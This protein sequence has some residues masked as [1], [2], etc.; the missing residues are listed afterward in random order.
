MQ[1][2]LSMIAARPRRVAPSGGQAPVFTGAPSIIGTPTVGV[3]CTCTAGTYTGTPT[4]TVTYQWTLNGSNISGATG[5]TYSPVSGD[6]GGALRRQDILNN[7]YGGPITSGG[8]SASVSVA[9]GGSSALAVAAAG[10]AAGHWVEFVPNGITTL[11]SAGSAYPGGGGG[12]GGN[13][14]PYSNKACWDATNKAIRYCGCDHHG[15]NPAYG[16]FEMQY[17]DS[18]NTWSIVGMVGTAGNIQFHGYD[19][20]AM[21]PDTATLYNHLPGGGSAT[22]KEWTRTEPGGSWTLVTGPS[23]YQQTS[24]GADWWT[25]TL[26][27]SQSMGALVVW[28]LGL[29]DLMIYDPGLNSWQDVNVTVSG[30]N[31]YHGILVYSPIYNCAIFGGGNSTPRGL[32]RLNSDRTVTQ[33][34]NAPIDVGIQRSNVVCDPVSGKFLFWGAGGSFYEMVPTGSGTFTALTG[35]RIPPSAGLHG[36]SDPS[37]GGGAPDALISCPIPDYGV[38][39]YMSASGAS[40]ANMFLYKHA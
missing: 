26:S 40:Y 33:L 34:A 32:W 38:I 10:L 13:A 12:V 20:V 27:G 5:A 29:G 2:F 30:D 37:T 25:G 15:G 4:V 16:L 22:T 3:S 14:I 31:L 9:S 28:L 7:A 8:L 6:V 1:S 19:H 35:T 21:R 24:A 18:N 11:S 39:A 23:V 36:V 17:L